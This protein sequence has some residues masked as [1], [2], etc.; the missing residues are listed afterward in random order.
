VFHLAD[1]EL[2]RLQDEPASGT[3]AQRRHLDSCRSCD[4]RS[5]LLARAAER[6]RRTLADG[7]EPVDLVAA[8]SAFVRRLAGASGSRSG[9]S[10]SPWTFIRA[11][12]AWSTAAA[13]AALLLLVALTPLRTLATGFLAI[14]EPSQFV[15][16]PLTTADIEQLRALPDLSAYGTLR[17]G[18]PSMHRSVGGPGEASFATGMAVTVPRFIPTTIAPQ[19]SYAVVGRTSA[20][21]TF[22]AAKARASAAASRR[23]ALAVPPG[24]DGSVL[25]VIMGPVVF[26]TYHAVAGGRPQLRRHR[27]ED[28]P[29]LLV[30]QAPV[31]RVG[32]SGAS[33]RDIERYLLAQPG[34]PPQLAAEIAAIGDPSTTLPIPIPIEKAYAQ[35]V[36]VAGARGLAMGDNTG[37]GS[38]VVWQDRGMLHAVA[39]ALTMRDVLAVANSLET[40]TSIRTVPA[41]PQRIRVH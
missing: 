14:F 21:F 26:A 15:A 36:I 19:P 32:S 5:A 34:V 13:V 41:H 33:V 22:S 37:L 3:A 1:G 6:V 8:R 35:P 10:P 7:D 38:A 31:P 16:V 40:A 29:G 25:G 12:A 39:G 2:R 24:L 27:G 28:F 4:Q 20:S 30:A 17:H 9:A 23:P 18:P 11:H